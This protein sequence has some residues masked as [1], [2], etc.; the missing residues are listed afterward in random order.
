MTGDLRDQLQTTLSGSYTIERELGGGGMSKVFVAE[1]LRLK[2]KVVVKVLSP[3]LAQGISVDRFEREIQTVAALQHANIVPVHTAGDT[4][5][6]PFYTMPFVEGES[7][8]ARLGHGPLPVGEV[9]GIMRD[10]SKAL[11]YAHQRGVVHRDIKPDNVLIS[12]GVA[13]VTDFGIAKAINASRTSSGNATLTQI[14]TSIGTPAYM[15]PEQAAGDPDIDHRADIYALGAMAYEL[16]SGQVVFAG[17]TPQRMLAAHMAE[18]P[19][20]ITELR[21]DL[22]PALADLVMQCLAKEASDRPQSASDIARGLETVTSSGSG[23]AMPAVLLGGPGMFKKALAMYAGAF[24]AVAILAKAAIVGIGLPDWVF[25]GSLIVMALGLPLILWTGYV[26]RVARRAMTMTPTYTLGGSPLMMQGTMATIALKAAPRMSWYK[27]ARGGMYV[28]G[29]FIALIAT[30]MAMRAFGI[31][32]FGSLMASGTFSAKERVL[33]AEFKGPAS[34]TLLGPTVTEAFRTDVGQSENLSVVPVLTVQSALQRMQKPANTRVDFALA[35]EMAT[36]DGIKAVIDGEIVSLGGSYVLSVRLISTQSGEELAAFRE[37]AADQKEIIP[38][39]SRISKALRSKVGESLRRVQNT[40]SMDKVSTASMEALQKYMAG[41]RA[42]Y[43]EGDFDSA[44]R[45]LDEAIVL[46]SGF[47]MAYRRLAAILNVRGIA[48]ERVS[49]LATKAYEHR[50]RLS[51]GERQHAIASYFLLGP[52]P[53]RTKAIAAYEA[54]LSTDSSDIAALNNLATQYIFRRD[55]AKA[56]AL[57][58]RAVVVAPTLFQPYFA[59]VVALVF[60]GKLKEADEAVAAMSKALPRH[61]N[62]ANTRRYLMFANGDYTGFV[63]LSDSLRKAR[64]NDDATQVEQARGLRAMSQLRGELGQAIKLAAEVRQRNAAAGNRDAALNAALDD[65]DFDNRIR[66]DHATTLR[67]LE[68]ALIEH[69][70]DSIGVYNRP[71]GRVVAAYAEA[72]KPDLAKALLKRA[73]AA[74]Y[75]TGRDRRDA[76]VIR[77]AALGDIALSEKRYDDAVRE[78]RAGDIRGCAAC[79]LPSIARAFDRAGKADSAIAYYAAYF[80]NP[81]RDRENDATNLAGSHERLGQLYDA[82]GQNDKAAEHY[83]KFIELWKNADPELQ[84][85][86]AAA[87]DRLRTLTPTERPKR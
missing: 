15:A 31:G 44:V 63:A 65:V 8:R 35:R 56:E 21:G 17:R 20:P 12:G 84:P 16:L 73:E 34:D 62:T 38:A 52:S 55:Y 77:Q 14:G 13:V 64:P 1:E 41:S 79:A 36:R 46:D 60:Q 45:L 49:M 71:Y 76:D 33:L 39:I 78:Y 42:D 69:P 82:K 70:L 19:K 6:L 74:G 57:T 10:V 72:G 81:A 29:A 43:E 75:F 18:A 5:G 25:P 86:V 9:I 85:R 67:K 83:R 47:A 4:N 28:F 37:T 22:S 2:R 61:P 32:P 24:V 87:K 68:R 11:A 26:Q 54:I 50:D 27:T 30:Y 3:E 58:R 53:D 40:R 7:L 66:D 51:D 23:N 80:A 48:R 59:L